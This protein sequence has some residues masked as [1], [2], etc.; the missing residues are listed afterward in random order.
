MAGTDRLSQYT[1][2]KPIL[3]H[4]RKRYFG[5]PISFTRYS[6]DEDKFYSDIG[7]LNSEKNEILLYRVLDIKLNRSLW[8][9][10]FGV[11]TVTIVTADKTNPQFF[12]RSIKN[13]ERVFKALSNIVEKERDEKRVLG[14][15]M[16]GSAGHVDN[17]DNDMGDYSGLS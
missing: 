16:Y 2:E 17:L 8:Q 10:I 4:D 12:I 6:F 3:W 15:E 5:L 1:V 14:K 7:L 9:K 13:S 11:G